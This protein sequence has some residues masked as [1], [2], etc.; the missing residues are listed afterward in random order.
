MVKMMSVGKMPLNYFMCLG[1]DP[2]EDNNAEPPDLV[3]RKF[4]TAGIVVVVSFILN[5]IASVISRNRPQ[6]QPKT[7]LGHAVG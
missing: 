5:I 3:F 2:N 7:A 4:D 6:N 1:K